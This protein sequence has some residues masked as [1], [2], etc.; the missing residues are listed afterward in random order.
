MNAAVRGAF[1]PQTVAQDEVSARPQCRTGLGQNQPLLVRR[2]VV[3]HVQQQDRVTCRIFAL[4]NVTGF[5]PDARMFR[6]AAFR[7]ADF[8]FVVIHAEKRPCAREA[9]QPVR[10][11][12]VAAAEIED[13][14]RP[15]YHA[16]Q[17]WE[18]RVHL[19]FPMDKPLDEFSLV[20]V[21]PGDFAADN[22]RRVDLVE[23]L[24][25]CLAHS[26]FAVPHQRQGTLGVIK[27][28]RRDARM[29]REL[30]SH[31]GRKGSPS[32]FF[33]WLLRS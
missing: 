24:L 29:R 1:R 20:A 9:T 27:G 6:R 31:R 32:E 25:Q 3:Q 26:R 21:K 28:L 14:S 13:K 22:A 17:R 8:I 30:R 12:A 23:L 4:E 2:P 15:G 10:R 19:H 11:H 7:H 33:S 18:N 16:V 5:K